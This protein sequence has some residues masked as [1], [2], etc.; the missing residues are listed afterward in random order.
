MKL[1][2]Q[3]KKPVHTLAVALALLL[4]L[5]L[6]L[7]GCTTGAQ[8][9][10]PAAKANQGWG[11]S[12]GKG[13][14][15]AEDDDDTPAAVPVMTIS[16]NGVHTLSGNIDGQVLVTAS[17]VTL[18]LDGATI[19]SPD[20]PAILGD[21]GDGND[22]LQNLTI[23]LRGENT[24]TAGIKHGIQGKDHLTI[25]GNGSVDITAVKDGLHA[26][27]ALYVTSGIIHVLESY[28]GMEAPL[29]EI[30]GGTSVVHASDDGVNAASD[31][32]SVIP[33]L[34]IS[35]GTLTIYAGSDGIDSNGTLD[36]TGGTVAVF[37]NAPRDGDTFDVDGQTNILPTIF[38]AN[39][40][41]AGAK[42]S[43]QDVFG[44]TLWETTAQYEATSFALTLPG[45]TDGTLYSLALN[46]FAPTAITATTTVQGM[47]MGGGMG[48]RGGFATPPDGAPGTMP[49]APPA[50][51]NGGGR[52]PRGDMQR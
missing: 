50:G 31:D 10:T 36:I 51:P 19:N 14:A 9:Q 16:E 44:K 48:G 17:N 34:K 47:R 15:A 33:A 1:R 5:A 7:P 24:L 49:S 20:G 35:G 22:T 46:A 6:I 38:S 25:T 13:G 2:W 43:L 45:L 28:E 3:K 21:D 52:V 26:G 41:P 39:A 27:D 29:I 23:E 37:I 32:R 12:A 11:P 40:I 18:I 8:A 4:L 30:S 42:V